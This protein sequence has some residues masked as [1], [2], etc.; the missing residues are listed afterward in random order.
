MPKINLFLSRAFVS[1]IAFASVTYLKPTLERY[2]DVGKWKNEDSLALIYFISYVTYQ[3]WM[4]YASDDEGETFT[5]KGL[6]GRNKD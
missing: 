6:P 4:R 2:A 1:A 5:P 3:G